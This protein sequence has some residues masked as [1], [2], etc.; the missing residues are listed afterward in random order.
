M[1]THVRPEHMTW[2]HTDIQTHRQTDTQR[3]TDRQ[4]QLDTHRDKQ[5]DR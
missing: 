2:T 4:T 5:A 3:Q 1:S